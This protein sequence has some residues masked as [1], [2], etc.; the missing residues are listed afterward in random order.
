MHLSHIYIYLILKYMCMCFNH[1]HASV[2]CQLLTEANNNGTWIISGAHGYNHSFYHFIFLYPVP[3]YF[4]TS[5]VSNNLKHQPCTRYEKLCGYVGECAGKCSVWE[6]TWSHI[7]NKNNFSN[8]SF[9]WPVL[10]LLVGWG[11]EDLKKSTHPC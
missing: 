5:H 1:V 7:L 4:F 9:L 8:I 6:S 10:F 2:T 11:I 3:I